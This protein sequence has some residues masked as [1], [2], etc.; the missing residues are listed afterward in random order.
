[1][2]LKEVYSRLKELELMRCRVIHERGQR[3]KDII[4]VKHSLIY[5][6]ILAYLL[7]TGRSNRMKKRHRNTYTIQRINQYLTAK[8]VCEI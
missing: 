4:P 8:L 6:Q 3:L 5:I 7:A 1:M 2:L